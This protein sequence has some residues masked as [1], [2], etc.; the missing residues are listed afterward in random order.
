MWEELEADMDGLEGTDV[1]GEDLE[2]V[3]VIEEK[4]ESCCAKSPPIVV[5]AGLIVLL[6]ELSAFAWPVALRKS[7]LGAEFK[8]SIWAL[9]LLSLLELELAS[10]RK[11]VPDRNNV[12][13]LM[14]RGGYGLC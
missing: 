1:D 14:A 12:S 7:L 3:G 13:A 10:C 4:T 8:K 6:R 2:L 9:L 11:S 5:L